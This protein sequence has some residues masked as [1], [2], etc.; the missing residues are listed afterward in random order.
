VAHSLPAGVDLERHDSAAAADLVDDIADVYADARAEPP[1]DTHPRWGR[2]GFVDRTKQQVT[3]RDFA[4]VTARTK[5]SLVGFAFGEPIAEGRWF[6][7][8]TTPP[9]EILAASKFAVIEL[10]VRRSCRNRGIGRALL[11]HLLADRPEAYAMLSTLPD[12][13]AH[14][15]YLRWGWRKVANTLPDSGLPPW[16]TLVLALGT[17]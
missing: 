1:Y 3:H 9:A 10:N 13:E 7:G 8:D 15:L 12:T 16:D 5:D 17:I 2:T 6:N 14:R 11:D 4:L